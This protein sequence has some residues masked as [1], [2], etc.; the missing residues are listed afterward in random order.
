M[1]IHFIRKEI[2]Q[3]MLWRRSLFFAVSIYWVFGG[4]QLIYVSRKSNGGW[5]HFR[6]EIVWM[7]GYGSRWQR[8]TLSEVD[9]PGPRRLL[10]ADSPSPFV[11][12]GRGR[13]LASFSCRAERWVTANRA[14]QCVRCCR[15]VFT[16]PAG[17][18]PPWRVRPIFFY[19]F[20]SHIFII[21][22]HILFLWH[23]TPLTT[24]AG[25]GVLVDEPQNI[26]KIFSFVVTELP[27]CFARKSSHLHDTFVTQ[28]R[29]I[30]N[31]N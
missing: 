20:W 13:F 28:W 3:K 14:G 6:A 1:A 12:R 23:F 2:L 7:L 8:G 21:A 15:V 30:F 17:A 26:K 9:T 19:I 29:L 24:M 4:K 25:V 10:G 5:Q 16:C 11:G 27:F 31:C 18:P 22:S